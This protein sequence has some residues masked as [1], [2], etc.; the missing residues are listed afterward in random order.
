MAN[1]STNKAGAKMIIAPSRRDEVLGLVRFL[2][3]A[4]ASA[5]ACCVE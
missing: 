5:D 2:T 3:L 1:D 4:K